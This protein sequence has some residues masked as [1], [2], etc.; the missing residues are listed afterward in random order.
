MTVTYVSDPISGAVTNV[1]RALCGEGVKTGA[2]VLV[3]SSGTPVGTV[4]SIKLELIGADPTK[5]KL[6]D[7]AS[8]LPLKSVTPT[9]PCTPFQY[10]R[11]YG[12]ISNPIQLQ[13]GFTGN[14][15]HRRGRHAQDEH[16]LVLRDHVRL[17]SLGR[18]RLLENKPGWKGIG[19]L[20]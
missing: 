11:E 2:R 20:Q 15:G 17:Q 10:H 3:R 12:T 8:N 9:A 18:N 14:G 1:S 5:P 13:P 19:S 7:F 6:I 4:Y 16:G